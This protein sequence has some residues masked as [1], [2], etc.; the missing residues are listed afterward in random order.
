MLSWLL[1]LDC[2]KFDQV[3]RIFSIFCLQRNIF[4]P[5]VT[6]SWGLWLFH[7]T[8][9]PWESNVPTL[10][11]RM[12]VTY[13]KA[14][15]ALWTMSKEVPKAAIFCSVMLTRPRC[16]QANKLEPITMQCPILTSTRTRAQRRGQIARHANWRIFCKFSIFCSPASQPSSWWITVLSSMLLSTNNILTDVW[17]H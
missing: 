16:H 8:F 11:L 9:Y 12:W 5:P 2:P 15:G 14:V 6:L 1:L 3:P 10:T 17:M 4:F 7:S 13:Q